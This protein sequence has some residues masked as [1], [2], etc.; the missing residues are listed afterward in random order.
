MATISIYTWYFVERYCRPTARHFNS[1]DIPLPHQGL[2]PYFECFDRFRSAYC[3]CPT[4][5]HRADVRFNRVKGALSAIPSTLQALLQAK[6][7]LE[8]LTNYMNQ[9]EIDPPMGEFGGRIICENATIGWPA[10]EREDSV[11]LLNAPFTLKG[12]N[13]EPPPNQMTI[14]CGPLGS[15]K[16]L[17]VSGPLR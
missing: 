17:F 7:S 5:H 6:V 2:S 15:G 12:L 13:L 8:R 10:E 1:S 11:P 3:V 4:L 9:P 14:V 16:T